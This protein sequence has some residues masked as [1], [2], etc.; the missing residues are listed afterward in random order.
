MPF[1]GSLVSIVSIYLINN[2]CVR[3][4]SGLRRQLVLASST[5]YY[6][7]DRPITELERRVILAF[8]EGGKEAELKV[9]QEAE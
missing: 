8:E 1:V 7:D 2:P 3:L 9:R 5:L 6:L 4:I